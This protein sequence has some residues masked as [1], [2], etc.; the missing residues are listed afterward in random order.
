[1]PMWGGSSIG[2]NIVL[3]KE[4]VMNP[5]VQDHIDFEYFFTRKV[6]LTF[7]AEAY[8]YFPGGFGTLDEF[9]EILTL[10]QTRK[11]PRVPMI[12]VGVDFW[13]PLKHFVENLLL[14]TYNTISKEELDLFVITDDEDEIVRLVTQAPMRKE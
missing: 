4:Q 9:F 11:I 10:V 3:P 2:F 1:L 12:L 8:L 13:L 14:N 5:Y 7:S 6:C